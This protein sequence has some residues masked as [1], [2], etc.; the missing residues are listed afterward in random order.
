MIVD[1]GCPDV[2]CE[3][4]HKDCE[5]KKIMKIANENLDFDKIT[6]E[7]E[8]DINE[9]KEVTISSVREKRDEIPYKNEKSI[10]E[11]VGGEKY[12]KT[13]YDI[14]V[15]KESQEIRTNLN[16]FNVTMTEGVK[17]LVKEEEKF[18]EETEK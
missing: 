2:L 11:M 9:Q 7:I 4:C 8:Q 17:P 5:I 16:L 1:K 3:E 10:L 13:R 14:K 18:L 12:I 15:N 6:K